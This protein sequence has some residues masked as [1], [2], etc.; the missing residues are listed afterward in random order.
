MGFLPAGISSLAAPGVWVPIAEA[1]VRSTAL[2]LATAAAARLLRR[3]SAA[4]RHWVWTLGLLGALTL[5]ALSLTLPRW[6]MPLMELDAP[7]IAARSAEPHPAVRHAATRAGLTGESPE[8]ARA[9]LAPRA[10][11]GVT[12]AAAPAS[13]PVLAILSTLWLLGFAAVVGRLLVGLLAVEWMSRRSARVSDAPWLP[14]ARQ[15]AAGIGLSAPPVFLRSGRASMPMACGLFRPSVLMPSD[16]D[17]WPVDRLRIVLLH[18]LAH[19][20]RRDCLTHALAQIACAVHWYNPLVWIA[21]RQA[22]TE[23]ERACDD[24]VLTAGT[25]GS[26]YADQLLQIAREM[27]GQRFPSLFA[28]ATLAMAHR[29]QLEGRLMSILE[30]GIARAGLSRWRAAG[31]S[32][33]VSCAVLPLATM[34]PWT[35][36]APRRPFEL[37]PPDATPHEPAPASAPTPESAPRSQPAG[38]AADA[39]AVAEARARAAATGIVDSIMQGVLQGVVQGVID[40]VRE[41]TSGSPALQDDLQPGRRKE[42][43]ADPRLI[44]ALQAAL[45]DADTEVREAAIHALLRLHDPS[46][47]EPLAAALRDASA[48]IREMAAAGLAELQDRRAI[49]PLMLAL[50]DSSPAVRE[51][52]VFALGQLGDRATSAA[53]AAALKDESASV[54]E[55]AAFALAQMRDPAHIDVLVAALRDSSADVREQAAFAL[56]QMRDARVVAPLISALKD[57]NANVREL[58]AFGLAQ[59]RDASAVEALVVAMKDA[60]ADVREQVAFALGQLRDPRAIDALTAA[61]KDASAEVRRQAAFA[62]GQFSR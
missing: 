43:S 8:A 14:L 19:V 17:S 52:V 46:I 2:L 39:R 54:R 21:A 60:S 35:Y 4:T 47:Y 38:A 3:G 13:R 62:L 59:Q 45:K 12:D 18:E 6:E 20:K 30:P 56:G 55:Q 11:S 16:A 23:R 10:S 27:R 48:D 34:Q 41:A 49:E 15:L 24:L 33:L 32:M 53:V 58:A 7:A 22:R 28:G 5:P 57:A 51:Q 9:R 50:R 26:D 31:A 37:P 1:V 61:L 44:A 29:T 40:G 36:G 25:R 42:T